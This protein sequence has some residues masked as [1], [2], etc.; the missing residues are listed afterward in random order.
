MFLCS[1]AFVAGSC[2][3][4]V[5]TMSHGS[6]NNRATGMR[7]KERG[8]TPGQASAVLQHGMD[9]RPWGKMALAIDLRGRVASPTAMDRRTSKFDCLQAI[10]KPLS[11]LK[12]L[13]TTH[14]FGEAVGNIAC[15]EDPGN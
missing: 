2:A 11:W 6:N 15:R 3:W 12:A 7:R 14:C 5:G 13:A 9:Q 8:M 10:R 4:L 1:K